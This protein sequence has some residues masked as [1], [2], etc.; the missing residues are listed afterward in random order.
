MSI[1]VVGKEQRLCDFCD[2]QA[3]AVCG[4]CAKDVCYY[5]HES[6]IYVVGKNRNFTC[7]LCIECVKTKS[8]ADI[9]NDEQAKHIWN[10]FVSRK[11][12]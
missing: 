10:E 3:E 2:E 7:Y 1:R 4:I 9:P 12:K 8:L 5:T 11:R 6:E